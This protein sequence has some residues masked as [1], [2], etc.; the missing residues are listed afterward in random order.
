MAIVHYVT[1][2]T[3]M[4]RNLLH[5]LKLALE[6]LYKHNKIIAKGDIVAVKLHFGEWG[7]LSFVR[8]QFVGE[9]VD[10]IKAGKGKPFLTDTNTLYGGTRS[11]AP[12][13][14][15]TALRNGFGPVETGAPVIIADGLRGEN[16]IK[17]AIDGEI[18]KEAIIAQSIHQADAMVVVSHFK[19]HELTGFGGAL[20]NLGMGCAA[21]EGKMHQHSTVAP[22]VE[23]KTCAGCGKCVSICPADAIEVIDDKAVKSD[24]KCIGCADCI[25]VCPEGAITINWN[26]AA[27][28]VMRKIAEYAAAATANKKNKILYVNF[29]MDVSPRCDCWGFNEAPIAPNTGI[30]LSSD[31]VAVDQACID[32]VIKAMGGRDPFK[33]AHPG[34]DW[35]I[36]LDHAEKMGVGSR[37]YTLKTI[38]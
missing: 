31:P 35:N 15:M 28:S 34:P 37:T 29:I 7:N 8:P 14:I 18:V 10:F 38:D 11:S 32:L 24:T 26:E 23:H 22:K 30:C 1:L 36:T 20:K 2:K 3:R 4:G 19:G 5:K 27:G 12:D 25:V 16:K 13:H 33:E 9:I 6:R 21:R 17:V